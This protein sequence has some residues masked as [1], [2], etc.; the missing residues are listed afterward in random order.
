MQ[1]SKKIQ[2]PEADDDFPLPL[3]KPLYLKDSSLIETRLILIVLA[4]PNGLKKRR[5]I[6][7]Y[8]TGISDVQCWI[9]D[10]INRL[11]AANC[12]CQ[13]LHIQLWKSKLVQDEIGFKNKL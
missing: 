9:S 1:W 11:H 10:S 3:A 4:L 13:S 8:S 6:S 7:P 5:S 12:V 2:H